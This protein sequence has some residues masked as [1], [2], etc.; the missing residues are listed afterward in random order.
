MTKRAKTRLAVLASAL[1]LLLAAVLLGTA[2][3]SLSRPAAVLA[4]TSEDRSPSATV[5][6]VRP[7]LQTAQ[8]EPPE[9]RAEP[10]DAANYDAA[11]AD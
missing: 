3:A 1:T 9:G 10:L 6:P 8:E 5:S 7:V 11:L 4:E 2:L